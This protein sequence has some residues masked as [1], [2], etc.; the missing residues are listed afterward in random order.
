MV[1][2]PAALTA[3]ECLGNPGWNW[4]NYIHYSKKSETYALLIP[5]LLFYIDMRTG[6]THQAN[7]LLSESGLIG[8]TRTT[9][10]MVWTAAP[11]PV[12]IHVA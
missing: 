3:R 4:K 6:S 7:S 2:K 11:S 10:L 1:A 12:T 9:G 5:A 8:T